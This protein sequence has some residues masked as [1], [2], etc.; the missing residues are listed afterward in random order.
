MADYQFI[1]TENWNAQTA[2]EAKS[3]TLASTSIDLEARYRTWLESE[4]TDL[5]TRPFVGTILLLH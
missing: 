1:V 4:G 5:N 2:S 3:S